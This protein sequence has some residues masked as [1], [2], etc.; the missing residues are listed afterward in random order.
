MLGFLPGGILAA[1]ALSSYNTQALPQTGEFVRFPDP[2]T[3]T[4]IVRLTSPAY[5]NVLPA[6][7]NRFVLLKPRV[8]YCSSDR[9]AGRMGPFEVDLRTGAIR[10]V[11]E[12]DALDP[13]SLSLDGSGKSLYFLDGGV[14]SE[15]PANGKREKKRAGALARDVASFAVGA[16][17]AELFVVRGGR[18]EQ[19]RAEGDAVLAEGA[20]GPCAVRPGGRGCLFTRNANGEERELWYAPAAADGGKP[21]MLAQGRVSHAYWSTDG[22]SV[23]FLRDVH[24][25]SVFVAEVH[26]VRLADATERCVSPT[27]QFATF[28]A[29]RNDSMFVGASKSK[30]QP[31]V[32]LLLRSAQ[33]EFTLCEHRSSNAAEVKPKFSPDSQRVYF[34][35]DREGKPAI[36]SV[37][38]ELL[39]EPT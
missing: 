1:S 17:R 34:Q 21:A 26:E 12:A 38:V 28:A 23:F 15:V 6:S 19:I 35:S 7:T 30:A 36:Y 9:V 10:Q 3:E 16:S 4:V 13:D 22:S 8:L 37:N 32:V 31:N 20:T 25:N 2:T 24:N 5:R 11:A 29:N 27:S 39:V 14:L 18:L 33:R